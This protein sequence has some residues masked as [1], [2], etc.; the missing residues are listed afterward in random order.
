MSCATKYKVSYEDYFGD[1]VEVLIQERGYVGA[2]AEVDGTGN[3]LTPSWDTPSDFKFEPI[4]GS[5]VTIRLASLTDYQYL[6]LYTSDNRK[7]K[8]IININSVLWWTG[9]IMP[10]EYQEP[11][12]G[13]PYGIAIIASDQ[14]GFLR[15]LTWAETG[16]MSLIEVFALTLGATGLDI[17]LEETINVYE[18]AHNKT[19]ADSPLDQTWID[20]EN[21]TGKSYYDV[22]YDTLFKFGAI[23][24][25]ALGE[26]YIRVISDF[27]V[28]ANIRKWTYSAGVFTYDSVIG[29][30]EFIIPTTSATA[31]PL[32]RIAGGSMFIN[33]PW[34]KYLLQQNFNTKSASDLGAFLNAF[35]TEWTGGNPD[36][37]TNTGNLALFR[38]G[39]RAAITGVTPFDDTKHLS[40][41]ITIDRTALQ[42]VLLHVKYFINVPTTKS[43]DTKLALTLLN[44]AVLYYYD[45]DIQGWGVA[46]KYLEAAYAPTDSGLKTVNIA[47][48]NLS[49]GGAATGVMTLLFY[50]P[51]F[52]IPVNVFW[53]IDE[54]NLSIIDASD[55][56]EYED[57]VDTP[58]VVSEKNNKDG[59]T[60]ELLSS[61]AADVP[62]SSLI[63]RGSLWTDVGLTVPSASWVNARG[64]RGTLVELLEASLTREQFYPAQTLSVIF[65]ADI[66]HFTVI[67]ILKEI[68]NHNK[69]FMIKRADHDSKFGRWNL[70]VL[71][72]SNDMV[73]TIVR[74]IGA[75]GAG[76]DFNFSSIA[77]S[78]QQDLEITDIIP[79]NARALDA[80]LITGVEWTNAISLEVGTISSGA[81]YFGLTA[82]QPLNTIAGITSNGLNKLA[83]ANTDQSLWVGGDP[84]GNWD[85][86]AVGKCSLIIT[87]IDN[88]PLK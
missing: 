26:W 42:R 68:N 85:T 79:A 86:M 14:L 6:K 88:D 52:A 15:S 17:D 16:S 78:A 73:R 5:Y 46:V 28:K 37:W 75:P 64:E 43:A 34:R 61:D 40:Q 54:A 38:F 4:N 1:S 21:Y 48:A 82:M 69:L 8:V 56:E 72:L 80:V 59:G 32:R 51:V 31:S 53:G 50:A 44:D 60:L 74:T 13:P 83:V 3:P 12:K 25:Q 9:F 67:N 47:T 19:S 35:F 23:L 27:S 87:Y 7:Y 33:A 57:I 77:N 63:Y 18:D 11:Y 10:D 70:E 36:D 49:I 39:N 76:A 58:V 22:L 2:L 71:E 84:T 65:Y 81:Q 55:R 62:N 66:N 24:K 45:F 29:D 30:T 41:S 20:A